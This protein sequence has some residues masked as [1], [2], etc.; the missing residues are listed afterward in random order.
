MH[1]I[2][3]YLDNCQI[4][5]KNQNSLVIRHKKLGISIEKG[6]EGS[7]NE[8]VRKIEKSKC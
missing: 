3:I 1:H 5:T 4:L 8:K 2:E 6:R 7:Q